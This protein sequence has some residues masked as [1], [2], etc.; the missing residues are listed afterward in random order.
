MASLEMDLAL[1][2]GDFAEGSYDDWLLDHRYRLESLLSEALARSM[3][4]YEAGGEYDGALAA[5]L[6]LAHHDPLREDAPGV[7]MRA[8]CRLAQ[9]RAEAVAVVVD[10]S[11]W[12]GRKGEKPFTG[13]ARVQI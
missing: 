3:L 11:H 9:R 1:Y 10:P 13:A 2:R 4:S 6:K 8:Y 5:A 7:A 12:A